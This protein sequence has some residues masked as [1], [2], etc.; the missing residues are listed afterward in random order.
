MR[1]GWLSRPSTHWPRPRPTFSRPP[2]SLPRPARFPREPDAA[3]HSSLETRHTEGEAAS[4]PC[5]SAPRTLTGPARKAL[6]PRVPDGSSRATALR[7]QRSFAHHVNS[8]CP[9]GGSASVSQ[10]GHMQVEATRGRGQEGSPIQTSLG[11][12]GPGRGL[13]QPGRPVPLAQGYASLSQNQITLGVKVQG[14]L[15]YS[16]GQAGPGERPC[17]V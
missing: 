14:S 13:R 15:P 6:D 17:C 8:A 16:R 4:G 2:S 3:R 9:V 11:Q 12:R 1:S 7:K 5:V 10:P